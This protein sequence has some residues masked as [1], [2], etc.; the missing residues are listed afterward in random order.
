MIAAVLSDDAVIDDFGTFPSLS[1]CFPQT[2][3][4]NTYVRAMETDVAEH[5]GDLMRPVSCSQ[6]L[7]AMETSALLDA[8]LPESYR[9]ISVDGTSWWQK[10][11]SFSGPGALVC[12]GYMDPGNWSTDIAGGS[13]YNYSL[14]SVILLSSLIA[15]FLQALSA[16]IGIVSGRDLAQ[17]CR[18]NFSY[19]ITFC[20]WL[21]MEIAIAATDL[22]ELIGSAVALNL[23]FGLP[24]IA[25]VCITAFD[26]VLILFLQRGNIRVVEVMIILLVSLIAICFFIELV[27]SDP[28][29]ADVAS[30]YIPS[31][32]LFSDP[33][34]LFVA[35][36]IIG[37]T[38]MP[39]NLFLHS[40][41]VLTRDSRPDREGKKEHI[42]YAV[43]DSS[44]ALT[45]AFFV[46]SSIL[47]VAAAAFYKN[48]YEVDD[49]GSAYKLLDPILGGSGASVLFAIALLASGQSSTFTGTF[50]G[51]VV[52]E[53]FIQLKIPM[54]LRR[55]ITRSLAVLPALI[56]VA[57]M[58]DKAVNQLLILSQ[59]ILCFALPFAVL[60]LV[61]LS[62]DKVV[63]GEYVNHIVVKVVA[64]L[65]FALITLLNSYLVVVSIMSA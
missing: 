47:I 56:C 5:G 58:G 38:V 61:Y 44:I 60:P 59:V 35:I 34:M 10:L 26:V 14:L 20:L 36:S 49:I 19:R 15:I 24:I 52:M 18:D 3:D 46:N 1:E 42:R 45:G 21:I 29:I 11:L 17:I 40:S 41:L 12:V 55:V 37:A 16:K 57:L 53:G 13:A 30:G 43:I 22:A 32:R 39:H 8:S 62:S 64:Y 63:M 7:D 28:V 4:S 50:A 9:S 33:N 2:E 48:G 6:S 54:T 25:G 51:Q 31:S 65:V 23:L 27:Y